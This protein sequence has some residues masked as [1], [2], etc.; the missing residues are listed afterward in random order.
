MSRRRSR[1]K[2]GP[3]AKPK[4]FALATQKL[5]AVERCVCYRTVTCDFNAMDVA[6]FIWPAGIVDTLQRAYRV[7]RVPDRCTAAGTFQLWQD[8]FS[9]TLDHNASQMC[10]P[11]HGLEHLQEHTPASQPII[12]ALSSVI[13]VHR[14]FEQVRRVVNWLDENASPGAAKYY[15]PSICSLLPYEHPV[16]Q[17]SVGNSY[18]EPKRP[19]AEIAADMREA[20]TTIAMGL[21]SYQEVLTHEANAFK[22]EIMHSDGETSQTFCLI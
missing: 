22:V 6:R 13:G 19:V 1:P 3:D 18:R 4:P 2:A 8:R 5:L 21:I 16:N 12:A 10:A 11:A 20:M 9:F 17:L 7:I 14:K 15:F